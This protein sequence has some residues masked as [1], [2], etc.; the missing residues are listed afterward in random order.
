MDADIGLPEDG[1]ARVAEVDV[2][3]GGAGGLALDPEFAVGGDEAVG[4][5]DGEDGGVGRGGGEGDVAID[6]VSDVETAI[7]AS[8][9]TCMPSGS[10]PTAT[11]ARTC[12]ES[13]RIT[14]TN[15]SSS[16]AI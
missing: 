14:V 1:A 5:S 3:G 2:D 8:G 15:A 11:S 10:T 4:V 7:V 6:V 9:L 12:P 16:F 13:R